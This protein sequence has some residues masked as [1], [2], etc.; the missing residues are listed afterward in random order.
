MDPEHVSGLT[1]FDLAEFAATQI[2]DIPITRADAADRL[3]LIFESAMEVIDVAAD[4]CPELGI[5]FEIGIPPDL[6][7]SVGSEF[8]QGIH[9]YEQRVITLA[10][11]LPPFLQGAAMSAWSAFYSY[12]LFS[13]VEDESTAAAWQLLQS[14]IAIGAFT[15]RSG[16][17][18]AGQIESKNEDRQM[19]SNTAAPNY[20]SGGEA[21]GKDSPMRL[22]AGAFRKRKIGWLGTTDSLYAVIEKEF[23][24]SHGSIKKQLDRE[25]RR[26]AMNRHRKQQ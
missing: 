10:A 18:V 21:R 3:Y 15:A 7:Q 2:Q 9:A 24:L 5:R 12:C 17:E 8:W 11:A 4:E 22:A 14:G 26:D 16:F 6:V 20:V 1:E 25:R 13:E 19:T 23:G